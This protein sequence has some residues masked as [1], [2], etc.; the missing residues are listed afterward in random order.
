MHLKSLLKGKSEIV[1][2]RVS[3]NGWW[4]GR[5]GGGGAGV[6][7]ELQVYLGAKSFQ[8][9]LRSPANKVSQAN[10]E[11][12]F[13]QHT[14]TRTHKLTDTHTLNTH[15]HTFTW[16]INSNLAVKVGDVVDRIAM[17]KVGRQFRCIRRGMRSGGSG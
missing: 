7:K 2:Q 12:K 6:Q 11:A 13:M 17:T 5:A 8:W 4:R 9:L 14:H 16:T 3:E 1:T 10:V 15:T